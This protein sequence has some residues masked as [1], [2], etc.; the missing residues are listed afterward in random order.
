MKNSFTTILLAGA[1]VLVVS[2]G[3][4]YSFVYILPDLMEEYYEPVFRSNSFSTDW[5]FYF[6]P[7][8][9]SIALFWFWERS[10]AQFEGS[11]LTRAAKVSFMYGVVALLPVLWLTFS[12]VNISAL[13]VISWVGYGIV[14]AFVACL[15]FAKR[16]S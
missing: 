3:L 1:T 5:L 15:I 10:K 12:A 4:L 2:L 6:H 16:S 9:L 14:Q 13:M 11:A 7:F 8:V